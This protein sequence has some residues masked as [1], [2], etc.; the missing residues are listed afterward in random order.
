MLFLGLA[1]FA[2]MT[3]AAIRKPAAPVELIGKKPVAITAVEESATAVAAQA[4]AITGVDT[5]LWVERGF[6]LI[7]HLAVV[8]GLFT[9]GRRHFKDRELGVAMA[10]L[11]L[12]V[13]YTGYL[14]PQ[15]H[16]VL[17]AALIIWAVACYHRP[18]WAGLLLGLAAGAT[19]FPVLLFPIWLRLYW[20]RSTSR[21][22][23]GYFTA[24]A[25]G[26]GLTIL[27]LWGA[28]LFPT[29]FTKALHLSDWQPWR[30][31]R[32]EGVW[33]G[34]HWAYRLPVF[35]LY[36]GVVITLFV[37]PPIRTMIDAVAFS[38]ALLLGVQFWY[39]EHGGMYVLWYL[40]LLLV[41]TLR[42]TASDLEPPVL[43]APRWLRATE[44]VPESH[45]PALAG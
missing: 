17:P 25:V 29:G 11:Y 21:F 3:A 18:G 9:I 37:W 30:M 26:V 24:L 23:I 28:G 22:L 43:A 39:A 19:F 15:L 33:Q 32:A 7:A 35:V 38:A 5:T 12:L 34:V 36:L 13:P 10:T 45:P 2:A 40:P 6:A 41:L 14:F 16:H 27:V 8:A 44:I 42:P 1:L 31:P 20:R 4:Q